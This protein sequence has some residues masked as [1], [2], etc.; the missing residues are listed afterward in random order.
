MMIHETLIAT[1]GRE[2]AENIYNSSYLSEESVL[3]N[4]TV[5]DK[6]AFFKALGM[7]ESQFKNRYQ[8]DSIYLQ[9]VFSLLERKKNER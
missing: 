8:N 9:I 3:K 2:K 4:K 1:F 7:T 6:E 5:F